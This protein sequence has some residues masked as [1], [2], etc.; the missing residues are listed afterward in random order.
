MKKALVLLLALSVIGFVFAQDEAPVVPAL[1][2]YFFAGT[3]LYNQ[4]GYL[5]LGPDWLSS[6]HYANLGVTYQA[7]VYGF[8]ATIEYEN[9]AVN[10]AFRDYTLWVK[11]FDMVKL[12]AGKLRNGDYRLTSYI[13]GNGF[14]TRTANVEQGLLAQLTPI[15]GL[16]VG[17]FVPL[18]SAADTLATFLYPS[19][20]ASYLLEGIAKFFVAYKT[21]NTEFFVGADIKAIEG[22]TLKVGLQNNTTN[23]ADYNKINVTAGYALMDGALDLGLDAS[24]KL[25]EAIANGPAATNT[26]AAK[27]K[28]AYTMDIFT[29][30]AYVSFTNVSTATESTIGLGLELMV[31]AGDAAV[32]LG[33]DYEKAANVTDATWSI[34]LSLEIGF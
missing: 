27:V 2:G 19:Y 28:A 33:F 29:P 18:S 14:S 7:P 25:A 17:A 12:S 10:T 4:D 31:A 8:S 1:T 9:A 23:N 11:L 21:N 5:S 34:P 32:Y 16:S 3:Q 13:D 22:L 26:L 20:G 6:G 30:S 24:Y 15:A